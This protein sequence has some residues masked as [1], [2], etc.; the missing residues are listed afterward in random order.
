MLCI[1]GFLAITSVGAQSGLVRKY[2]EDV[3]VARV[4]P[5]IVR[6]V[7]KW[8]DGKLHLTEREAIQLALE[9]NL[10]INVERHNRLLRNWDLAK[11]RTPY[12]PLGTFG[13]SWDRSRTPAASILQGGESVTDI[14]TDY[15]FGFSQ[16]YHT[17]TKFEV[18]FKGNRN[19]T[20]NFFTS[21]IPTIQTQFEVLFRQN[22]LEGFGKADAEYN[23]EIGRNNIDLSD[24]QFYDLVLG[25]ISQVQDQFWELD[26]ALKDIDVKQKSFDLAKTIYDQNQA[27]FEVGTASHLEVVQ[28]QA[29]VASRKEEL[30]RSQFT[31]KR[32]QDQLV[33]L[34]T[35]YDDPRK[36]QGEVIPAETDQKQPEKPEPFDELMIEASELRPDLQQAAIAIDNRRIE[37]QRSRDRLKPSLELVGGY[38][39]FGIG[40]TQVIR[41]YSQGFLN[42][43]I[44]DIIPGGLGDALSQTFGG[45]YYGYVVGFNLQLPLANIDAR[46]S[47]AQA[48]I[49][50]NRSEMQ[51]SATYQNAG[52]EIRDL[53]TQIEMNEASIEASTVAVNAARERMEGEEARF[54]VGMGTT[55]ELIE[56]QRDL[57]QAATVLIRGRIDLIKSHNLLDRAVGRTMKR[58]NIVFSETLKTNVASP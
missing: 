21:L 57:L 52:A 48:Q 35:G 23:L 46:A 29:E 36:F 40:G 13:F 7:G 32:T 38:Q 14:L 41:D 28:A 55:R 54:E 16:L 53:L 39:Q 5:G 47:N 34:V 9:N 10:D 58:Q 15:N 4:K 42:P 12:E 17:G 26:Y 2:Y 31:A 11:D 30:I 27:R 6:D 50:L 37:L 19:R 49:E 44:I 18:T 51:R 33:K 56:A 24:Q 43:P 8:I 1:S 22:L 20:T 45:T 3:P 25:V